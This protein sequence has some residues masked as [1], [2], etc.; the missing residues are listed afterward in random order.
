LF[1]LDTDT[2]VHRLQGHTDKVYDLAFS[3]DGREAISGGGD[4]QVIYWDLESGTEMYRLDGHK[5]WVRAVSISPDGLSA[6]T[7]GFAG[8]SIVSNAESGELILWDLESGELILRFGEQSG[9]QPYGVVD[10]VFTP[11]GQ[12]VLAS[13]G[14]WTDVPVDFTQI[15]WDIES[16]EPVYE[17]NVFIHDNYSLAITPDGSQVISGGSD[18]NVHFWDLDT[19]QEIGTLTGHGGLV[20][21]VTVSQD[22]RRA[23]TG[24]WN[25]GIVLWD[26]ASNIQ[27]MNVKIHNI[28]VPWNTDDFPPVNTV[29]MV[30]GR[31]GLSSAG[32]G[33]LVIWDLVNAGQI[34]RY[35]GHT[36]EV[37]A[38]AFTPDGKYILTGAGRLVI[39][40]GPGDDNTMQMWEL[41]TG[42]LVRTFEGHT[43]S[44]MAIAVSPDGRRAM[45]GGGLDGT[46]K[47]WNL[48][49][50]ELIRSMDAHSSGVFSLAF[51]PD[52]KQAL[53]G[54]MGLEEVI[55]WDLTTGEIVHRIPY[56][57]QN[58]T[59]LI[60]YPDGQSA[61]SGYDEL[62]LL[63]LES[64]E[65]SR[66]YKTGNCCTGFA[67]HPD[68]K[69]IFT[70]FGGDRITQWDLETDQ[71][72]RE[73]G[74]HDGSRSRLEISPDGNLLLS[75][76]S[77]GQ[78]YLW[79]PNTGNEIRRF[80]TD[81]SIYLFDID[82]SPDGRSAI[83][84]AEGGSAILWDLTLPIELNEVLEWIS[85]N[86]YVRDLTC[87]ERAR[88]S[89]EPLCE[90]ENQ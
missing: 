90:T 82:I 34:R 2:E 61:Y 84:P 13:Y 11:D 19:G 38:V 33:T 50:G 69:S 55:L 25:G 87:E 12:S 17:S 76:D 81:T 45:T 63:D 71:L 83:T 67:M 27:L 54:P 44:I 29:F 58:S 1:D 64:G 41:E 5:G 73:F 75:S 60:F 78:L 30:D 3:P 52:G 26:L 72:I 7:G 88:Y 22:G 68:W 37:L 51:S 40:G 35:D 56:L 66:Q 49:S 15:L 39:S 42:R 31:T 74:D 86:R 18:N 80:R 4:H 48:D 16:G 28:A 43:D 6:V 62:M 79:D 24:D 57:N 59:E 65:I 36:T 70:V 23:F 8:D 89:I 47:Y 53:S 14:I 77:T 21:S 46:V 20:S 85:K 10:A 9:G 32:D